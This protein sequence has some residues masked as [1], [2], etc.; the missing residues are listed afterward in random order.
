MPESLQAA[1][2]GLLAGSGLVLGAIAGYYG[3]LNKRWIAAIM[4]FGSGV[5]ISALSFEL[6]EEAYQTGGF[7]ATAA[8]FVG[9]AAVYTA[10][11]IFLSKKGARHRKSANGR[12]PSEQEQSGSGLAIALG[13]IMDGIPESLVI[14]VS[15]IQSGTVSIVALTA[16]FLSNISEGL[17]AS[18]GMRKKGRKPLY[19]LGIWGTIAIICAISAFGGYAVFKNFPPAAIAATM[20]VAAGAILVMISDTMMPEAFETA[21]NYAGLIT[22]LGFLLAFMLSKIVA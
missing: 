7:Y 9:G 20:A 8:G 5:L 17:A 19:V 22:V 12:Q 10:A 18:A 15:L 16:I 4:S 6:V 21:H 1:L 3:N 14:G 2:W 13:S 11:N